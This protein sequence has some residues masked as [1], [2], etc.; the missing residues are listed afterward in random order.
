ME[1]NRLPHEACYTRLRASK[2]HPGGVGVFAV[3]DIP[4][5]TD[6]FY[7]DPTKVVWMDASRLEGLDEETRRMYDD[8]CIIKGDTY[9]CPEDFN[10]LTPGWF[11]NTPPEG[12]APSVYCDERY[13]FIAARDI[14][15]GEELT[16][17][18]STYS[19]R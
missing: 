19:D 15:A 16:V 2:I 1:N 11:I 9:G 18:Y 3:R 12:E 7:G 8:F 13:E 17:D 4:K 10:V 6:I 5:E 14:K